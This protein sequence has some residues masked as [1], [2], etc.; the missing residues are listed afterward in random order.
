MSTT[1]ALTKE[2]KQGVRRSARLTLA[3]PLTVTSLDPVAPYSEKCTSTGAK[4]RA[5]RSK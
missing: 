2:T 5:S 3:V 4:N 1:T